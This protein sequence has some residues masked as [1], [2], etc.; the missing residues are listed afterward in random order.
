MNK[1]HHFFERRAGEKN[2]VHAF[3][4]HCR[5]VFLRDRPTAATEDLDVI[6]TAFTEKIDN[7]GEEFDVAAVVAGDANRAHIFLD[8]G[9]HDVADRAMIT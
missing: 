3:S 9:P 7:F 4:F 5:R 8:R 6:R 2:F 1:F